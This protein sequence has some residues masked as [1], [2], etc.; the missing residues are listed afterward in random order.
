MTD[1][2]IVGIDDLT[3]LADAARDNLG[4]TQLY[5]LNELTDAVSRAS[6]LP[7]DGIEGQIVVMGPDGKPVWD[8]APQADWSVSDITSPSYIQNRS[9]W[10]KTD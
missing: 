1:K 2:V 3:A 10:G 6:A 4:E 5:S 8:I 7:Q 9:H